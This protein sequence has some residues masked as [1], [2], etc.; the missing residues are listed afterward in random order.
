MREGG[1]PREPPPGSP[2]LLLPAGR[3]AW[4]AVGWALRNAA[5]EGLPANG[6]LRNATLMPRGCGQGI[7][8]QAGTPKP[9]TPGLAVLLEDLGKGSVRE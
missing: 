9:R 2:P 3:H 4:A 5:G 8:T 1:S 7:Q 6:G